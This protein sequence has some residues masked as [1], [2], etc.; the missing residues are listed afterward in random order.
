MNLDCVLLRFVYLCGD[1][2]EDSAPQVPAIHMPCLGFG[3][4]VV[5]TYSYV[6]TIPTVRR[7]CLS[8]IWSL[9]TLYTYNTEH[10]IP[11]HKTT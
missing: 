4:P 3:T 5:F 7:S 9:P 8:R 11:V 1:N 2:P 10:K 6:C